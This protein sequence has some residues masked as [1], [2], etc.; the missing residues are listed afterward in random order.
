MTLS[1]GGSSADTRNVIKVLN[2]FNSAWLMIF[3]L[4]RMTIS[5]PKQSSI[6]ILHIC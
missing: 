1:I 5:R 2:T 4:T 6:H 3:V